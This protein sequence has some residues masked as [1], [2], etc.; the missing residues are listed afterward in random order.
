MENVIFLELLNSGFDVYVGYMRNKE[1]DFVAIKNSTPIYIQVS[2][3][4]IDEQ[5]IKREYSSLES[6]SDNYRKLYYD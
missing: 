2:Y 4:L 1:V 3:M 6:I 5:T